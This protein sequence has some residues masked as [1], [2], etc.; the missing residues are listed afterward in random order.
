[1]LLKCPRI[2]RVYWKILSIIL[3]FA[4]VSFYLKSF[5]NEKRGPN[6]FKP[7][8]KLAQVYEKE[9]KD[10]EDRIIPLL[11]HN[12]EPAYLEGKDA[13]D[14]E[15]ALKKFAL[16]TVLSDRMPLDRKLRDPRNPK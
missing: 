13:K 14:G 10:Y 9:V 3:I 4:F 5:L 11:G 6:N 8:S 12:G 2:K 15:E 16:N 7:I 1:M